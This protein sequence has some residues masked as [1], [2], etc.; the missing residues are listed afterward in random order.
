MGSKITDQHQAF[1]F[2]EG[3][4]EKEDAPDIKSKI[5]FESGIQNLIFGLKYFNFKS[6]S[7]KNG[8]ARG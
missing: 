6:G 7:F 5:G 3:K 1:Y 2:S 8:I 4:K